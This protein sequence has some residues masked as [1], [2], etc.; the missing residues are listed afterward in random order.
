MEEID[1]LQGRSTWKTYIPAMLVIAGAFLMLGLRLKIGTGF[2]ND[3]AFMMLALACYILAALF[4]LTNLYA[5]SSMAEKIGFFSGA[6]GVFFNLS[7]W[8]IRWVNALDHEI[9]IMRESGNMANPWI[10]RYIPFANL[11]DLSLAFAFGAG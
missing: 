1:R 2:V 5:P 9:A 11:Y 4:Q 8:L 7:S 3:G 10:F 6:L